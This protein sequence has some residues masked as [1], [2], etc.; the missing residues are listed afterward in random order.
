MIAPANCACPRCKF[1]GRPVL[2]LVTPR[3]DG[4]AI[5][6]RCQNPLCTHVATG[7]T[8]KDAVDKWLTYDAAKA[9]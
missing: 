4:G 9:Q 1:P 2:G 7:D 3:K 6:C 8:M 5:Y